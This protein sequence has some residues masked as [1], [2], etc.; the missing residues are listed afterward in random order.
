MP[1][2]NGDMAALCGWRRGPLVFLL[3]WAAFPLSRS[4]PG[5]M[6]VLAFSS[7]P[8]ALLTLDANSRCSQRRRWRRHDAPATA[9]CSHAGG[10]VQVIDQ[11]VGNEYEDDEDDQVE[12]IDAAAEEVLDERT[13]TLPKGTPEGFYIIS[14]DVVP[15]QGLNLTL[16]RS[17]LD[18]ADG[19]DTDAVYTDRVGL[20]YQNFTA[21]AALMVLRPDQYPSLSKAR[22]AL[23][24]GYILIIRGE[25]LEDG[26]GDSLLF[27]P[28]HCEMIRAR[29]RDRVYPGDAVA[30]Q[31]RLGNAFYPRDSTKQGPP[32]PLPVIY[33]DDH[34]AIVNKPDGVTVNPHRSSN[35]G[36]LS[37]RAAAPYVLTPP[38]FGTVATLRRPSPVHRLDKPT[39]GLLLI[40]KTKPAMV[41]LSRQLKQRVVQ[42]TYTA[43][44]NGVPAVDDGRV[45]SAEQARDILGV[46]VGIDVKDEKE[47]D[48]SQLL[49]QHI[50]QPLTN[51]R[52]QTQEAVTLW[53]T[54]RVV[55]CP[56]AVDGHLTLVELR[57]KTGRYHQLRKH[58]A[59]SC[60]RPL[61][62]DST[63]S[64]AA[65]VELRR[66]FAD[67]GLMLC[68]NAVMLEHPHYN[69]PEGR[70]EWEDMDEKDPRKFAGGMIRWSND[71][72]VAGEGS[73]SVGRPR[74]KLL[75]CAEIDL[76]ERFQQLLDDAPS[77]CPAE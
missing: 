9:A 51:K 77:L 24:K 7:P 11:E 45:V 39:S 49:W 33:E 50:S 52:K 18:S 55:I 43:V 28:T 42:K 6:G 37:V 31:S 14:H 29:V 36:L 32:F 58:M 41:E 27:D 30:E 46:D 2:R 10:K 40:A 75:V 60:G 20:T 70:R 8:A 71:D 19:T 53:R 15:P 62:G 59:M 47:E 44:V 69:T 16:A 38:A 22:K 48:N 23:R 66:Q 1:W 54:L 72:D 68:S 63:Y 25:G 35:V 34:M 56:K 5:A 21:A 4:T 74:R 61:V 12:I 13:S 65:G 57:P 3:A 76:P 73:S 17:L 67:R 26:G 64:G